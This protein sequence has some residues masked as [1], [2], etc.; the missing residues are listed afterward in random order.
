MFHLILALIFIRPF[1]SSLA[2][3]QTDSIYTLISIPL[4]SLW[5]IYDRFSFKKD[6]PVALKYPLSLLLVALFS[7]LVFSQ[8]I[9]K[10]IPETCKYLN[11][12][13]LFLT[14]ALSP[15]K[16]RKHII[17]TI[18]VTAL[19]ISLL[20]F[21]QHLFG[22]HHT[23]SY[24]THKEINNPVLIEYLSRKRVFFPFI[25]PNALACYLA[26][27]ILVVLVFKRNILYDILLTIALILTKS[28]AGL[29]SVLL[30]L[31]LYFYLRKGTSGK[32]RVLLLGLLAAVFLTLFIRS[33]DPSRHFQ[34]LFSALARYE[35]WQETLKIITKS[36]VLGIG[37]G[38]LI[39]SKTQYAHNF[40][41]QLWAEMG[42][43]GV[44]SFLWFIFKIYALNTKTLR[45][46]ETAGLI[47][48]ISIFLFHNLLDFSFSLPEV[49]Y[50]FW[51]LLG[52]L[53]AVSYQVGPISHPM[54]R[55]PG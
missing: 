44:I 40:I 18:I 13:L 46:K 47:A 9:S 1:I 31:S 21:Y 4:L 11:G 15:D 32:R 38:N 22:F 34:P 30:G 55:E 2:F 53:T 52:C 27:T 39:L 26:V 12:L 16:E 45:A 35:Y 48:G 6:I 14:A 54:S 50:L 28:L 37:L 24:L 19:F 41:L 51:L 43:L 42:I 49:N 33:A 7:S 29:C 10:S 36:P 5:L 20:A 8:N 25:N 23:L 3:P 17:N